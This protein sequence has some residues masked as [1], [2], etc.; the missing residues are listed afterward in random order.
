[1]RPLAAWNWTLAGSRR[2]R[3][4]VITGS[5]LQPASARAIAPTA[6]PRWVQL[7]IDDGINSKSLLWRA[8][9]VV[10]R[11]SRSGE[12]PRCLGHQRRAFVD[13]AGVDLDEVGPR[14]ALGPRVGSRHDAADTD[15]GK[16]RTERCAQT[17]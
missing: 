9:H 5:A 2:A 7:A 13:E 11:R 1:M 6:Q 3:S 14:L 15:D 4:G 8:R 17:G 12:R 16:T 10:G